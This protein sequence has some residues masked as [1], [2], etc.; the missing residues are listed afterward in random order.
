MYY[1]VIYKF[2]KEGRVRIYMGNAFIQ[3]LIL[4]ILILMN[5]FFAMSEIALITINDNKIKKMAENGDKRAKKIVRLIENSSNFLAT[6]QVG[7]T[8]SGFLTSASASQSFSNN[9]AD[10]LSF[11][12]FSRNF[13]SALSTVII[14]IILSYFSLVLGELVPKKIAM[15]KAEAISFKVVNIL[16][17][18]A[19]VF[20]PFIKFLSASTNFVVKILGFNPNAS[21]ETVTEEEILMMVD[22]GNE[23]GVIEQTE[24]D[25]I[26]NI[27]DFDN[28]TLSEVMTHRT[29]M[30]AVEDTASIRQ[31]V[32]IAISTGYSRIPVFKEDLDNIIGVVYV[33][34]L[35]KY[36]CDVLPEDTKLVD[37]MRK[38]M[39]VPETKKCDELFAE[40]T[41]TKTQIA[42]II[43]EYGGTEGIITMED[44]VESI[45][46]N[47]QDEYD[48]EEEEILKE[49][50][51]TFTVDGLTTIDEISDLID[52]DLPEGDYDTIAGLI[53]DRLGRIP[54]SDEHPSITIGNF[55]FTVKEVMDKRISKVLIKNNIENTNDKD[56][57]KE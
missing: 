20:K 44:L 37:I 38:P 53:V 9:L 22:V 11:L 7:V 14:T 23:K 15:Q 56:I 27:F 32:N 24:K 33:K 48:N 31:A 8:L 57:N 26:A 28:T 47:I 45:L 25:M 2:I 39:F 17:G 30:V 46:G 49:D 35:L 21:E 19:T 55:T 1:N 54:K 10:V 40:M 13:I 4:V 42:I 12:P 29:D 36:V 16:Q 6:I 43:D 3:I 18:V 41:A 5:A 52:I 34:D 50:D 51:N